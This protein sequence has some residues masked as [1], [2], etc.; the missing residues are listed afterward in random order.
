M[1]TIRQLRLNI[2][3]TQ[4]QIANEMGIRVQQYFKYEKMMQVP[5]VVTASKLAKSLN[6]TTDV[7]AS[8][9]K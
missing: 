8:I 1:K 7:I 3:K 5:N 9:Y 4:E 2:D 6:V